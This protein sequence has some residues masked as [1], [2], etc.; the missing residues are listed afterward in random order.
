MPIFARR[1]LSPVEILED[2]ADVSVDVILQGRYIR[3]D[4]MRMAC[5]LDPREE[6]GIVIRLQ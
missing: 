2:V 6:L 1:W 3:I 4:E 5:G